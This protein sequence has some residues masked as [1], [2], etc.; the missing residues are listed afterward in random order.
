VLDQTTSF[1]PLPDATDDDEQLLAQLLDEYLRAL[2][3]GTPI[4]LESL[5]ERYPHLSQDLA[6]FGEGIDALHQATRHLSSGGASGISHADPPAKQLGDFLLGREIGRGGMGIVYEAHQLSLDRKVAIKVLPL[7]AVWDQKQ[8]AR[9]QNEARAAAQLQHP[10]IVPVFAVGEEHGVHFYAMQLIDGASLDASFVSDRLRKAETQG[11]HATSTVRD[12]RAASPEASETSL[13]TQDFHPIQEAARSSGAFSSHSKSTS[14]P[15]KQ[16]FRDIARLGIE[17]ADALQHAHDCGII[18][19]DVKPSNLLRD[20]AGKTWV[21]DFGLARIQKSPNVTMTGDMVGT[22]RYMSP[23]QAAGRQAEVDARTDV[24]GLGTTL[25]ELLTNQPPF[26]G[27]DRQELLHDITTRDP[28]PPRAI[29]PA[30]PRDLETIVLHALEKAREDRYETAQALA[31]D[32]SRFLAGHPPLARRPTLLDHTQRWLFRHR[33]SA[34]LAVVAM[35]MLTLIFG[36]GVILL[37]RETAAKNAALKKAQEAIATF[38]IQQSEL[39][40]AIPG[41]ERLRR[42][43]LVETVDFCESLSLQAAGNST[44]QTDAYLKLA[45]ANSAMGAIREA[46]DTYREGKRLLQEQLADAPANDEIRE[47][48]GIVQNNLSLVLVDTG[49]LEEAQRECE[50]AIELYQDLIKTQPVRRDLP[51]QLAEIWGNLSTILRKQDKFSEARTA[52]EQAITTLTALS[53]EA[54][55][56]PAAAHRLALLMTNLS[57]LQRRDALAD[58]TKSAERAVQLLKEITAEQSVTVEQQADLARAQANLAAISS[59]AGDLAAA[60]EHLLEAIATQE[61]LLTEAPAVAHYRLELISSFNN[62]ALLESNRGDISAA[63]NAFKQAHVMYAQLNADYPSNP[64]YLSGRAAVLNNEGLVLAG[65]GHYEKADEVYRHAEFLQTQVVALF[66]QS[67][68]IKDTLSRIYY[69]HGQTLLALENWDA[70]IDTATKRRDLWQ[71]NGEQLTRVA[72]EF[73]D[74][75]ALAPDGFQ[76]T[77]RTRVIATLH[78]ALDAGY[79]PPTGLD[80]DERFVAIRGWSESQTLKDR[81]TP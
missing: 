35:A 9:F 12:V 34:A 3:S 24:Y 58:A 44:M 17:A 16:H 1:F 42:D 6:K 39:L 79:S 14:R 60:K 52:A 40:K 64:S 68:S 77:L 51:T 46:I 7:A 29:N 62:L 76:E 26:P 74:I 48:L 20:S 22:L 45:Q 66:P 4:S 43:L 71:A 70:A 54:P 5:A 23:E 81:W 50:R 65:D 28:T 13:S 18:H 67:R 10:H 27:D 19:R 21:A 15:E 32:L 57:I 55:E 63:E 75:S 53:G 47:L 61:K 36:G 8:V 69:N 80:D 72:G 49:E 2:E 25:Y 33:R 41:A 31:T 30:I 11:G 78:E 73:L 56:S 59:Q 38:G 37:A